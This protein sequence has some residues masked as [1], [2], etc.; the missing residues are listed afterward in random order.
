MHIILSAVEPGLA[1]AWKEFCGDVEFVS[2]QTGSILDLECDA[3]VSPANSFGFMDGGI[4]GL[5]MNHFGRDIQD[6]V[7]RQI[8]EKHSGE[9]VVGNADIIE[10]GEVKIPFLMVAP[11]MRVPMNLGETVN[12]Y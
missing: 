3:V 11:T 4:D 9:L 2:V 10:T 6:R 5:Y 12:P 7:R 1:K 8:L